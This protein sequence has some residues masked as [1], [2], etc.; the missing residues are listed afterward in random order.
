[1][2]SRSDR[3]A[4][5]TCA[6]P[7]ASSTWFAT[8]SSFSRVRETSSTSPPASPIFSAVSRPMPLDAPVIRILLPLI[9]LASERSRN[10]SGSRLRS[11]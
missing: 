3:S 1:M 6:T 7:P 9:E 8:S 4:G 5:C 10:R 2:S 11:Q